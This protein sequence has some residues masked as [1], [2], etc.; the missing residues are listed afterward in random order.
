VATPQHKSGAMVG[1]CPIN[2]AINIHKIGRS[3]HV[4]MS[5]KLGHSLGAYIKLHIT[6][7]STKP[8]LWGLCGG[9]LDVRVA[10]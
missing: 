7:C 6:P 9:G 2:K 10:C 8:Y 3:T 1:T 5:A 4:D